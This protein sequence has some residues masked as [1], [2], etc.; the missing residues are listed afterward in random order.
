VTSANLADGLLTVELLREIP[1]V[2]R[3]RQIQIEH[4]AAERGAE[5]I[6]HK[7]A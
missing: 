1:E 2:M 7:A 3:P 4:K 5:Q 6:E